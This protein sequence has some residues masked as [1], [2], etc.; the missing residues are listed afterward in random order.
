MPIQRRSN[1]PNQFPTTLESL[2]LGEE[3]QQSIF[4]QENP[5]NLLPRNEIENDILQCFSKSPQLTRDEI[6]RQLS[7]STAEV[8]ST[9][10]IMEIKG[11][12]RLLP[13]DNYFKN[14]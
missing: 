3:T 11:F 14:C 2:D 5:I 12:L 4:S 13:P 10:S 8:Q 1:R 9:L 6:I 7:H